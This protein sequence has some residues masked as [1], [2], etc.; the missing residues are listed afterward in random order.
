M[1]TILQ[2][3]VFLVYT[4]ATYFYWQDFINTKSKQN[5]RAQ[6]WFF[7]AV[8]LHLALIIYFAFENGR[9]PIATVSEAVSTF[10][11]ITATLYLVIEF[12]L[13]ERSQGAL[14][15]SV[16]LILLLQSFL[17]FDSTA[18]I[19]P[20]L[21]DIRFE[22][23]V[24]F[25]LLGYSGFTLSVIASIL[26][27]LL[28]RE[29]QKKELGL[30]FRKLPS[31]AYFERISETAINVGLIFVSIGF[32]LGFYF[33]TLVWTESFYLDPKIIVVLLTLI[34]YIVHL[35]GRKTGKIQGKHAALISVIGFVLILFSFFIVSKVIPGAHQF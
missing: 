31:L 7:A 34:V 14:I 33:A 12:K 25:M 4:V 22:T 6:N 8:S 26:F 16:V 23:H 9:V 15:L 10:V 11:W 28:Y 5:Q 17:T 24:L 19:N 21:Y 30:F 35:V 2:W 20:V 13:K 29:I 3:L 32:I 27:L 1:F 18:E